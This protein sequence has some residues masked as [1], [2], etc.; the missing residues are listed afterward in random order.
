METQKTL[1]SQSNLDKEMQ[2]WG[3]HNSGF[4]VILQSYNNQMVWYW[5]KN[6]HMDQQNTIEKPEISPQLYG[7]LIFNQAGKNIQWER[8]VSSTN[9]VQK[10]GQQHAK[11]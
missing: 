9:A 4:Q 2:N 1:G 5:H 6:R 11:E 7:R 8:T 3:R 10:T